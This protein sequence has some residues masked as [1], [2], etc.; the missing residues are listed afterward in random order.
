MM[1]RMYIMMPSFEGLNKRSMIQLLEKESNLFKNQWCEKSCRPET[2][3]PQGL[4]CL[5]R[6]TGLNNP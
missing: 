5:F 6:T 3:V 2:S 4:G 1:Y